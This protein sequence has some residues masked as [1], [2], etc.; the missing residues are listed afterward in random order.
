M[1]LL[2]PAAGCD[3][4]DVEPEDTVKEH[5]DHKKKLVIELRPSETMGITYRSMSVPEDSS[6][7]MFS[8]ASVHAALKPQP[9]TSGYQM[10]SQ[11]TPGDVDVP[12]SASEKTATSKRPAVL[13][14]DEN[15]FESDSDVE[16]DLNEIASSAG[17]TRGIP[18]DECLEESVSN[19]INSME[20]E[21]D[22]AVEYLVNTCNVFD[23]RADFD[24]FRGVPEKFSGPTPGSV[25]DYDNPYDVFTDIWSKDIM[26]YIA[27]ETNRYA[28]QMIAGKKAAGTLKESSRLHS[29]VDTNVDELYVLFAAYILM[30]MVP[31][32][33][34]EYFQPELHGGWLGTPKFRQLI[35][36]NRYVLLNKF[37]HF[38]DNPDESQELPQSEG[39]ELSPML[40]KIAPVLSHLNAKFQSNYN[41]HQNVA[42]DDSLTLFKG[43]LSWDQ[44]TRSKAHFGYKSYELCEL[45]TG[46]VYKFTI[47]AG[48]NFERENVTAP[49]AEFVGKS[50][51]VF[52]D[53][54]KGLE[55]LGH[56]VTMDDFYNSP[57]LARYLKSLG[58]D[59]LGTLRPNRK[60]VPYDIANA[61]AKVPNGTI[62]ARHSGDIACFAWKDNN[63]VNMISTYHN[64]ETFVHEKSGRPQVKP[65]TLTVQDSNKTVGGG[66]LKDRNLSLYLGERKRYW[67]QYM[68]IFKWLLNVSVHNSLVLLLSSLKRRN[69]PVISH[70]DFRLVLANSLVTAHRPSPRENLQPVPED[71]RLR[72][73]IVHVPKILSRR[74]RMRCHI[75]QRKGISKQVRTKCETCD[76]GLCFQGC[77]IDWHSLQKLPGR[78]VIV[79]KVMRRPH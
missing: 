33:S 34:R 40:R 77:W 23:W 32:P 13:S 51:E 19:M 20:T 45:T 26:E 69:M 28:K 55:H 3:L 52:L 71:M 65:L 50:A 8:T 5:D 58:F 74:S 46:Y 9:G 67:E 64:P 35:S 6:D 49:S 27:M 61:S 72:R 59:C 24:T 16:F 60:N 63:M 42:I 66:D 57:S 76:E 56:C 36:Y 43:W 15:D 75:C 25:K 12:P 48:K 53:M 68:K 73:D 62:I 47:H 31:R 39:A 37:I 4:D 78:N 41:L 29:W 2:V 38:E 7:S 54:L 30:R 44:A 79:R 11:M 10:P 70:Q 21:M 14:A 17:I 1:S 22:E 18:D